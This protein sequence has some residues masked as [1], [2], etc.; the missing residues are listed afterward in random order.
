MT[1]RLSTPPLLT[2][3]RPQPGRPILATGPA[4]AAIASADGS[5]SY[6]CDTRGAPIEWG[7]AYA[8]G[9]RLTGPSTVTVGRADHEVELGP[10]TLASLKVWRWR[11]EALHG[12]PDLEVLDELV[13]TTGLPG[14]GRRLTVG[15][16]A[17]EPRRA[18]VRVDLPLFLAPVLI[19]GVRPHEFELS[20][21]EA[22]VF[23]RSHGW[24]VAVDS[25]PLPFG[26]AV[27]G[28]PWIG[29]TWSGELRSLRLE[30]ALDVPAG[31]TAS[32]QL[33]LWG[34]LRATVDAEPGAGRA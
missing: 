25:D 1:P 19:E 29:G 28:D 17:P 5:S 2:L 12:V 21:S 16:A 13:P 22:T 20:T 23:A 33:L 24:A 8:Q 31:G 34:G 14:I 3:E 32:L 26:L 10:S 9:I 4:S 6:L 11:W 7:G 15:S 18:H 30:Y 27:D